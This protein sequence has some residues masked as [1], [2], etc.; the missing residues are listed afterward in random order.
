[1]GGDVVHVRHETTLVTQVYR[2]KR[3]LYFFMSVNVLVGKYMNYLTCNKQS[4]LTQKILAAKYFTVVFKC[5]ITQ[6]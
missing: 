3:H 4:L 2:N 1:M 6:N 5:M